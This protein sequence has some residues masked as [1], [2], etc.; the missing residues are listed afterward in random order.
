MRARVI[1]VLLLR[2]QGLVKTT[3]FGSPR[4]VGDPINAVRIFN[5]KEVDE[6]VILDITATRENREPDYERIRDVAGESFM[7]VGYGGG[8]RTLDQVR[9][10]FKQGVEKVILNSAAGDVGLIR[11]AA[12][13]FGSQSIVASIDVRRTPQ[14]QYEVYV[15]S[16]TEKLP[17]DLGTHV[18]RVEDAGV[19][20]ILIQSIDHEG[21]MKGLDLDLVKAVSQMS[22]V[23]VVATGGVGTLDHVRE[24]I[25]VG[26]A[27]AVA[28]GSLFV[29]KGRLHAV[30]INYPDQT[31]LK[32]LFRE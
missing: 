26:G 7:P 14:G 21:T 23:P 27:S 4:Y 9:K 2:G 18:R 29:Y 16:G 6:L 15:R 24:G 3:N 28:A 25:I 12:S 20:E 10:V 8:I 19:G 31:K 11:G 32:G 30:L 22:S 13:I 1:P 17:L 5:E